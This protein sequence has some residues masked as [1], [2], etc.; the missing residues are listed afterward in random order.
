MIV[1]IDAV[2]LQIVELQVEIIVIAVGW[3]AGTIPC[4]GLVH[5]ES[6]AEVLG[7]T[8]HWY[9]DITHEYTTFERCL[10]V[11]MQVDEQFT[12][13][14]G[15]LPIVDEEVS[16]QSFVFYTGAVSVDFILCGF[17]T[18]GV[19]HD[20]KGGLCLDGRLHNGLSRS[21]L[22]ERKCQACKCNV[23]FHI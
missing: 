18:L 22:Q 23:S 12:D 5:L 16:T 11:G 1:C 7:V 10:L 20:G 2:L 4:H 19:G 13:G 8:N 3:H 15:S 14:L 6:R 9:R 21:S 17:V